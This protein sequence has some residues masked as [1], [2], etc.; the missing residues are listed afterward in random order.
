ME[1]ILNKN[2]LWGDAHTL[3]SYT[4]ESLDINHYLR[5]G[6]TGTTAESYYTR[7]IN[8]VKSILHA[9]PA[10]K[11]YVYRGVEDNGMGEV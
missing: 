10:Y 9:L 8:R 6:E 7:H 11:G 2:D 1:E 4:N 3:Q 5:T